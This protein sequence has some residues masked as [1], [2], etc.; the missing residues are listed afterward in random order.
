MP[1][2]LV[3]AGAR[4][5]PLVP[6]PL[7]LLP[8]AA[9]V[10][11]CRGW[12]PLVRCPS[13]GCPLVPAVPV[14]NDLSISYKCVISMCENMTAFQMRRTPRDKIVQPPNCQKAIGSGALQ[15]TKSCNRPR[16]TS[17]CN[18]P[19]QVPTVGSRTRRTTRE[20]K[21]KAQA[22]ESESNKMFD[23][24]GRRANPSPCRRVN[25]VL[26]PPPLI[27]TISSSFGIHVALVSAVSYCASS[28]SSDLDHLLLTWHT[29]S[30]CQCSLV[31]KSI[32]CTS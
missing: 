14:E 25:T 1:A 7:H 22:P 13:C 18:Q 30:T 17:K 11:D 26:P 32:C 2:R 9:P 10:P 31:Q 4:W 23:Q 20:W 12:P 3:P 27:S 19:P 24:L 21:N 28:A 16:N 15:E 6:L 5:C 29:C 8:S